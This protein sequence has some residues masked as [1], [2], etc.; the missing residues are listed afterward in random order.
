VKTHH[1]NSPVAQLSGNDDVITFV[2]NVRHSTNT[3]NNIAEAIDVKKT[4]FYVFY[5]CHV[6]T[7]FNVFFIL[8]TFFYLKRRSLKIPSRSSRSTF[9]TAEMHE[10]KMV[11]VFRY[12]KA[13]E[14]VSIAYLPLLPFT[15]ASHRRRNRVGRVGQVLHRFLGV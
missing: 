2:M 15:H 4:H 7:F 9:E 1:C 3:A 5:S 14:S 6:F 12:Y 10:I 13:L 8:S 11:N